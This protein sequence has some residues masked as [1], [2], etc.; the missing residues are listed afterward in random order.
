M[1]NPVILL[2]TQS[3][4]ETLPLQ[5]DGFGRTVT[6]GDAPVL[7]MEDSLGNMAAICAVLKS[8]RSGELV[9]L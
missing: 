2:G 3:N 9:K 1:T 7:S 8:A 4:G 5:V 6:A